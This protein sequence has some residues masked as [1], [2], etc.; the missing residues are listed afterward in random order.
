MKQRIIEFINSFSASNDSHGEIIEIDRSVTGVCDIIKEYISK[1]GIDIYVLTGKDRI[2]LSKPKIKFE[3]IYAIV[4]RHCAL[5]ESKGIIEFWDDKQ[6]KLLNV[7]IPSVRKH[8]LVSYRDEKHKINEI[9]AL[10]RET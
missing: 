4:K 7:I 2:F 1:R 6:N 10:L 5:L 9:K 8:F 3:A